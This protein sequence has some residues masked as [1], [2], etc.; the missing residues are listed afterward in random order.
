MKGFDEFNLLLLPPRI[1]GEA[2][3][4]QLLEY[5]EEWNKPLDLPH[6]ISVPIF[7]SSESCITTMNSSND[8][9]ASKDVSNETSTETQLKDEDSKGI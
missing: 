9:E 6:E 3:P 2:L 8:T 7:N 1:P 5:Y 4:K